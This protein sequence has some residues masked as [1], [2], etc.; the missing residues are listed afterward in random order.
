VAWIIMQVI[1]VINEPL[2]LPDWFDTV[3]IV[4]L[5]IGFPIALIISWAFNVTSGGIVREADINQPTQSSGR[6]IE[7]VL[8]GLVGVALVW[9]IY[10]TEFDS[11]SEPGPVAVMQTAPDVLPNSVA[12]L[13]F[14]NLSPDPDNA[15]FAAGIH[16]T[17]LNELAKISDMN[18]IARTTM[19]R[20][21]NTEKTIQQI[22]S[23][24]RVQAVME[25]SI[26]VAG[27]QVRVI[28]QL[29]DPKTESHLWSQPYDRDFED[30]F[31]IQ[32]DIATMIA[33]ALQAELSPDEEVQ[34][35]QKMTSSPEAYAFYL[36]AM[37]MTNWDISPTSSTRE[38][39]LLLDEAIT[40]DPAFA[41]AYATKAF[42]HSYHGDEQQL[43][44]QFA[45]TA[46][47]RDPDLGLSYAA[48]AIVH[49]FNI[50]FEK[51]YKAFEDAYRRSPNDRDV[52]DN[53]IRFRAAVS[54]NAGALELAKKLKEIDPGNRLL[55]H[56]TWAS[57][58]LEGARDIYRRDA[59]RFPEVGKHHL[60]VAFLEHLLGNED[61]ADR[62]VRLARKLLTPELQGRNLVAI[63]AHRYRLMG[64]EA[65]ADRWYRAFVA[66]PTAERLGMDSAEILAN[67]ALGAGNYEA[68]LEQLEQ[69]LL[70]RDQGRLP[71]SSALRYTILNMHGDP[72][73]DEP[74][75]M[76]VRRKLG[77]VPGS[78]AW[79]IFPSCDR[80]SD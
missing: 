36:R 67:G 50:Q 28:A 60:D 79:C 43:A 51:A 38:F 53:L 80:P 68:A 52:I 65:D 32:T 55:G 31:E 54:D 40:L 29:I 58:D 26:Q 14:A 73:L 11:R 57:G 25:G 70:H 62:D 78:R 76:A 77:Y 1:D 75:F 5:G 10:R 7:F 34:L 71:N 41:R 63:V 59:D 37:E 8:F 16:D 44:L 42:A 66:N 18:V 4:F 33:A 49:S 61:A 35:A 24:L 45:E 12:V 56:L 6:T 30:I 13:P 19:L 17:I 64:H 27:G 3:V 20:Y 74:D 21:A 48:I 23:E 2:N 47:D 69:S 39:H 72:R 46:I 22:A 9:L 15:F